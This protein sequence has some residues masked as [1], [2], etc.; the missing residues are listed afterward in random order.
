[1]SDFAEKLSVLSDQERIASSSKF[2][3]IGYTQSDEILK[4]ME[5]LKNYPTSLRMPN[6]LLV[7]D[8]NNG[9]TRILDRFEKLNKSYIND[10]NGELHIPTLYVEAPVEPDER[11][12]Y[13]L[14]LEALFAPINASERIEIRQSRVIHLLKKTN[15]KL[16]MIDEI[17]HV[18]A[19]TM[20]KQRTF[21]NI[22]KS[23]SNNT[24][25]SIVCA[26][27]KAAFNAINTDTQLINRFE[28]YILDNWV[29]NNEY[30]KLLKSFE[31]ILPLKKKSDLTESNIS[32]QILF[33]SEGLIGEISKIL[34]LSSIL[35]IN[36]GHEKIDLEILNGIRFTVPSKRNREDSILR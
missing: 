35:A 19:G 9:K 2:R 27:T 11:R 20:N 5:F 1:M 14:I 32:K 34:E 3:W 33:K 30:S 22:I 21:L 26:G 23:L 16:L 15:V 13:N 8:S 12:L 18:L 28:P 7:S 4:K 25:I 24:K 10:I 6:I 36:S 31:Q 17:H 29:Y